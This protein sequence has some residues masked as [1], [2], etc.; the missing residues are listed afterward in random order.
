MNKTMVHFI[1]A[2]LA[3]G[4]V[5][6]AGP[7][8][9]KDRP[10]VILIVA[11][12]LG[13][14]DLGCYGQKKI[15]T[16]RLDRMAAQG[17]RF[18]QFYSGATVC[19]PSRCVLMTGLHMG[20]CRVRGN[21]DPAIQSL[22][23]E[24]FTLAEMLRQ[25]GY[26]TALLGK[27]GLGDEGVGEPGH[28]NRQG[29]DDFYGYLNQI[30]AHNYYPE[31]LWRNGRKEPLR[32][33]VRPAGKEYGG[34]TGGVAQVKVDYSHDRVMDES[35]RWIAGHKDRPFFLYLALTIPHA[36]N[37]AGKLGQE[38][39]DQGDYASQPWGETEKNFAAMISRM[40]R[41]VGTLLDK[42]G[43]WGIDR[44]TL[45]I[46]TSDNGPHSEGGH[47]PAF[48]NSGGPLRGIKRNLYEGGV[49]VPMIAWWPG[50][51]NTGVSDHIGY[52][53]DLMATLAEL[54]GASVPQKL[55]SLSFAP[56]LLGRGE[57]K[58]HGFLYWESY[59]GREAQAVR[60]GRWKGVRPRW[61]A[62][63]ELYDLDRDLAERDN[64]ASA[65]PQVVDQIER[66]MQAEH[67]PSDRWP[68]PK[69]PRNKREP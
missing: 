4:W 3:A 8:A 23:D 42:L 56:T 22:A 38:V 13:Y 58:A 63:I 15:A 57:P 52:G 30:H 32:N 31:F 69:R 11:D 6:A 14:G 34:F 33:V 53:G 59:E 49:R 21:A 67:V 62:P 66:I 41:G 36:N 16:P 9:T 29:F 61:H 54:C 18:T 20:H 60:M 25:A 27:W 10:N 26:A 40:D 50:R 28:P 37:E 68:V 24:D 51:V 65:Q 2:V 5:Q 1:L 45:V 43:E 12:D 39:P 46:F 35:L 19:A 44:N 47:D 48:F 17:L 64:L 55:D 7:S